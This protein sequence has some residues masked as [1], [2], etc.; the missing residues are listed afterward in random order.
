MVVVTLLFATL[1]GVVL[2]CVLGVSGYILWVSRETGSEHSGNDPATSVRALRSRVLWDRWAERDG[3]NEPEPDD[4]AEDGWSFPR[5]RGELPV[6]ARALK[7]PNR[8]RLEI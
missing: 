4:S 1:M 3:Y 7:A 6:G 2:G 5:S 8:W